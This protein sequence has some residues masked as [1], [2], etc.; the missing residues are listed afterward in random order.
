MF[1]KNFNRKTAHPRIL[2]VP[3]DWGLGHA[4][5]CIPIIKELLNN[6]CE[7]LIGAE[8]S[9]R[10]L[11]QKEFPQL[12]CLPVPVYKMWYSRR[13]SFFILAILF[14]LP[15]LFLAIYREHAW[16]KKVVKEEKIDAVISDN[17]FGL[18]HTA[19][20]AAY[21]THQ[22]L[23]KTG[24][25]FIEKI[26]QRLHYRFI[27]KYTAC[28]V[29]DVEKEPSLGGALSHPDKLPPTIKYL[30]CLS[31]FEK[32]PGI[33]KKYDLLILLSGPEPQRSL[34]EKLLLEQLP[35]YK[36][37]VLFVR[38]LPD[39]LPVDN[40]QNDTVQIIN[41]LSA[42]ALNTA[43]QQA[44]IVI[45]R[46]GYTTVMDLVKLQQK[47]IFV[48]TPGQTEQEYLAIHLSEQKIAFTVEQ[49]NFS[50]NEALKQAESFSF[51]IPSYD[52]EQYKKT[53]QEFI[54]QL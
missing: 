23:I 8:G 3:L 18:Y 15:K 10:S 1:E 27:K 9:Q 33:E 34:F 46:S 40:E 13:K 4:T 48:P 45:S 5:R 14:Q 7:V 25:S 42:A 20:P 38:G 31:R 6:D 24:N 21:I 44:G 39:A 2:V 26:T 50:L 30:G 36:G 47:A 52:M 16:L 35:S 32:L 22:L 19:I 41:H 53:V 28:W 54:A 43:V 37:A 11:L 17:R 29:P 12:S 49:D 51:N